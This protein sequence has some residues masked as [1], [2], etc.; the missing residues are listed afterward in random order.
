MLQIRI[1]GRGG[2]GG[3][4]AAE[5]LSI[6]AFEQ[7]RRARAFPSFRSERTGSPVAFCRIDDA[8]NRCYILVGP[9]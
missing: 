4:T 6:T 8:E 3:V 2:Q 5:L 9:L 1:L 7:G